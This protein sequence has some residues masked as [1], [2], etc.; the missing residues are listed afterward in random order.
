MLFTGKKKPTRKTAC[1]GSR[2][3][4]ARERRYFS[5]LE[6][7]NSRIDLLSYFFC[8]ATTPASTVVRLSCVDYCLYSKTHNHCL[9][10]HKTKKHDLAGRAIFEDSNAWFALT[11]VFMNILQDPRLTNPYFII[12]SLDECR[13]DLHRLSYFTALHSVL[14]YWE[15]SSHSSPETQQRSP[16]PANP[17]H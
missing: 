1:S 14:D 10:T 9:L 17:A 13:T 8:Q 5:A 3:A 16:R 4:Q 11:E 15:V 2:V 12:D 6:S 7:S